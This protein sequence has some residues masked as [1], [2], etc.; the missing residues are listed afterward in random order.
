MLQQQQVR[1]STRPR[2]DEK[3]T[4][5][6]RCGG[7]HDPAK[8]I[9]K[10][11]VRYNVNERDIWLK[12]E[13]IPVVGAAVIPVKYGD[14]RHKLRAIIVKGSGSNLLGRD[15]LQSIRLDWNK[16]LYTSAQKP[17]SSLDDLLTKYSDVFAEGL[18]TIKGVKAKIYVEPDAEPKYVKARSV[19]YSFKS[20]MELEL[21]RLVRE[22]IISPVEFSGWAAP[23]VPVAKPNGSVR[24]CGDY[25]MTV[26]Q[27]SKL[28]NYPK[29]KTEDLL[30]TLGGG[31]KFIK[32]DMSQAYQQMT[33]EEESRKFTTINT[34]KGLFED[35]RLPFGVASAPGI[36]QRTME[37]LLQGIPYVI[38]RM[39]DLLISGKDDNDHMAFRSAMCIPWNVELL[40]SVPARHCHS[41]RTAS[42]VAKTGHG[43]VLEEG[44]TKAFETAKKRL[45]SAEL[46]VHFQPDLELILASD[47]SD[48]G[49]GV[50]QQAAPI[51]LRWALTLAAYEYKIAY[52]TGKANAN[53]VALSRFPLSEMPESVPIPAETAFLLE[54]LEETPV[55]ARHIREWTRRDPVLSR[56][57]QFALEGWPTQ[58][59]E[60]ELH[61][62]S[63]RKAE[64]TMEDGCILWGSRVIVQPQGRTEVIAKLHDAHPGISRMKALARSY[65]WWPNMDRELESEVQSCS[66]CQLHQ[67]APADAPLH[68]WEWPGQPWSR[69]H[70]DYAGPYKDA[71]SKWM[72]VHIMQSTTS[73][74]TIVKLRE[75]FAI[76]GLPETIVSEKGPNFTNAGFEELLAKN[77]IKHT[78]TAPYHPASNGQAERAVRVFKEGVEKMEVESMHAKLSRFLLKYRITP[79]SKT[80]VPPAQLLM[81]RKLRTKLDLLLPNTARQVRLT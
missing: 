38:V 67:K 15:W 43:M 51:V 19:P 36:F 22:G 73:A 49:K 5:C 65:V 58:C 16:I 40:P 47:A 18:G 76:H 7:S 66:Q 8:C 46:L 29:P 60:V 27:V 32:L 79:H 6:H 72:D 37:N 45:Q 13:E 35:N 61:P 2:N 56:V 71:Y 62:Y 75:I 57:Y 14:Q 63:S 55:N 59:P 20:N 30:A 39:D 54:H 52:K 9:F 68:T 3:K 21:E 42:Q 41:P 44:T 4:E 77:G 23:I 31:E 25:K 81:K 48:Y 80:V 26:N 53:A 17:R 1:D 34:H 50:P 64:L 70:I 12:F 10:N 78:K 74:A 11:E 33:L 69:V 28:D 24:I